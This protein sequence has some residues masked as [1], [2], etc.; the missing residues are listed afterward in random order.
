MSIATSAAAAT[1]AI[2]KSFQFGKWTIPT[3]E[4]FFTS[5]LSYGMVNTKPILPGHVL[6][7]PRRVVQRFTDLTPDEVTDLWMASQ[8]IGRVVEREF[9][10]ESLTFAIQDGPAAGQTVHHVHVH[11]IP[12]RRADFANNDDIYGEIE[13][14]EQAGMHRSLQ[15][16]MDADENRKARTLAE[17]EVESR[18]LRPFF[19]QYDVL[20]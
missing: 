19:E 8:A 16:G 13:A 4:V 7:V 5:R 12:R 9:R 10:G 20:E 6:V 18:M 15:Q 2:A 3:G 14:Q 1:R 17:M 11:V